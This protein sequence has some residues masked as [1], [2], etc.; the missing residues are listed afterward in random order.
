VEMGPRGGDETGPE[1]RHSTTEQARGGRRFA[2][3]VLYY[4]RGGRRVRLGN[5]EGGKGARVELTGRGERR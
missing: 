5:F 3:C 2:L 1:R 4:R